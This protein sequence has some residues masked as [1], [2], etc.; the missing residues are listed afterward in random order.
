MAYFLVYLLVLILVPTISA[1]PDALQDFCVADTNSSTIFM[2]GLPC[3]NPSKASVKHFTTSALS[4]P[5]DTSTN[6]FN[7]SVIIAT[8]QILPGIN[9]LGITIARVDLAVKGEVPPHFHARATEIIFVLEGNLIVGFVD[10]TYKLFST[11]IKTGDVFVFPKGLV[12]FVY[13]MGNTSAVMIQA[14]NGQDFGT[15]LIPIAVFHSSP[16]IPDQ[17]LSKAFQI[18]AAEVDTIRKNL[19]GK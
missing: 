2:N 1:D 18:S 8:A 5:G 19:G 6:V 3:I 7:A 17:V 16:G 4:K 9:T 10:T 14:F 11:E 12:H 15:T 13:N